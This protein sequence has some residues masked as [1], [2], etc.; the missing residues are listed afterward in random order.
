MEEV[1]EGVLCLRVK[2]KPGSKQHLH[3]RLWGE[4]W[5][6]RSGALPRR[7]LQRPLPGQLCLPAWES[8]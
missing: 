3:V 5:E 1:D 2:V 7:V 8:I 4:G 6:R